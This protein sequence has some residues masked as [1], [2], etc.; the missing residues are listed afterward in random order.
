MPI[1]KLVGGIM[2][3]NVSHLT[4][5]LASTEAFVKPVAI[6]PDIGGQPNSYFMLKPRASW[7]EMFESWLEQ[8]AVEGEMD[9]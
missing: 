1:T 5:Y 2:L 7:R 9:E 3:N 8:P 6:I 4:F